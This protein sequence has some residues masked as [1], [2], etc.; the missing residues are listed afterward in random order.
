MT[1]SDPAGHFSCLKTFQTIL[2]PVFRTYQL[3]Y[4]YMNL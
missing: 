3:G 1:L 2:Y 4:V